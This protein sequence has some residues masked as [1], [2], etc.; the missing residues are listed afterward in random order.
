MSR[1]PSLDKNPQLDQWLSIHADGTMTL[2]SGKVE[3]GQHIRTA[4]ALIAAEELDVDVARI[5]VAT[6]ETP[7]SP[8]ER[9]TSGSNSM[10]ESGTAIRM[11]AAHSRQIMLAK[12]AEQLK[13]TVEQLTVDDGEIRAPAIN[14]WTTYWAL[15]GDQPF[16]CAIDDTVRVKS[17]AKYRQIGHQPVAALGIPGLVTGSTQFVHDLQAEN[18][19]H[20]RVVRP[21]HYH[22]CL[23]NIDDTAVRAMSGV[24]A[25]VRNGSFLGVIAER[26]EQVIKAA[27]KLTQLAEWDTE[28]LLDDRDIF[29]QLSTNQRQSLAVADGA[30]VDDSVQKIKPASAPEEAAHTLQATYQRP[31]HMHAA[32]GP[33]AALAEMKAGQLTVWTHGQGVYPLREGIAKVLQLAEDKVTVIH[34]PGPG[35]YGHNGADDAALDAA[36]LAQALPDR[37]VLLKW[38][39]EDEH[40]WE[41]YGSAMQMALQA[42]LDDAGRII[43]WR[44]ESY[45][46][47]H[48]VRAATTPACSTL[49]AAWH[50]ENPLCVPERQ[51]NMTVNGGIH[52]NATPIIYDFPNQHIVKHLVSDLPLR[53]SALRSLGAYANVFALESFLDELAAVANI[54]PLEFRLNHLQDARARAVLEAVAEKANWGN[55]DNEEG[56]GQGL[57]VARYKNSKGYAAVVMDVSVDEYGAITLKHATIAADSGQIVDAEGLINQLEGGLIQAA[58]WTLKEQAT[59]DSQGITS[60]DWESYPILRFDEVPTIETVLINRPDEPY[61]GSGEATMGPTPA[62]IANAVFAATGLRLRKLP[63]TPEQVRQMAAET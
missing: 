3:L 11:A 46:D 15:Q 58:S 14:Q 61:L 49:L 48:V 10:E 5:K 33:S 27:N 9:Y 39:R 25:V 19:V 44:H 41:P 36:L 62:A 28:Q 23:K 6:V 13:V 32:L 21:P 57:A 50:V 22:A 55:I 35:C 42:S 30:P 24:L 18:M 47:T 54:D 1:S 40:G 63:F 38:S 34:Q 26:E 7:S 52:R 60:R 31:Y 8:N 2:R 43:A 59:F 37:P 20:G 53:V 17:A 56:R 45:S 4:L 16:N 51:P 12:A 29:Q